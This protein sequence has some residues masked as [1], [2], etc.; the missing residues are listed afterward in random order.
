MSGRSQQSH[1]RHVWNAQEYKKGHI[2]PAQARPY[3]FICLRPGDSLAILNG[4]VNRLQDS[5]S[6][7]PF[8]LRFKLPGLN[9]YPDGTFAHCSCQPLLDAHFSG[10]VRP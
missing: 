1:P 7:F 6:Q 9:R 5:D 2:Q 10:L 8:F 3:R 4:F